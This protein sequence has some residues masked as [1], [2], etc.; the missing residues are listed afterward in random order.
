MSWIPGTPVTITT[1]D[2]AQALTGSSSPVAGIRFRQLPSNGNRIFWGDST[3]NVVPVSGPPVGVLGYIDA[4]RDG[5]PNLPE[6]MSLVDDFVTAAID[7]S[8]LKVTGKAGDVV[9]WSYKPYAGNPFPLVK[10]TAGQH[11]GFFMPDQSNVQNGFAG[12]PVVTVSID[13]SAFGSTTGTVTSL[14][15]GYVDFSPSAADINGTFVRY[16]AILAGAVTQEV[17]I[18]THT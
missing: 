13:G 12:V 11:T 16:K 9:L 5:V 2:T 18:Y 4:P 6:D 15:N 10:N 1:D 14:G 7:P 8:T 3:L 17:R